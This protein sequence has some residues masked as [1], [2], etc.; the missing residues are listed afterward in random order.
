MNWVAVGAI[1]D[2]FGGFATVIT[3]F[4]VANELRNLRKAQF[5][6]SAQRIVDSERDLWGIALQDNQMVD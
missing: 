4:S 6:A 3:L 1:G 5:A 2:M